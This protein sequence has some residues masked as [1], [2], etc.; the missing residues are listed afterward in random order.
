MELSLFQEVGGILFAAREFFRMLLSWWGYQEK[1]LAMRD[2]KIIGL[3]WGCLE[4]IVGVRAS[5]KRRSMGI[6]WG[7]F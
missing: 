2:E 3:A 4:M 7:C 1:C 6:A 5:G